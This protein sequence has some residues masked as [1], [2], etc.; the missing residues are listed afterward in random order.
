MAGLYGIENLS[1][2]DNYD[3][4][5]TIGGMSFDAKKDGNKII[6]YSSVPPSYQSGGYYGIKAIL[7]ASLEED[8][9]KEACRKIAESINGTTDAEQYYL[10][11]TNWVSSNY[12]SNFEDTIHTGGEH[13][14]VD[15]RSDANGASYAVAK[16]EQETGRTV[17]SFIL[18]KATTDEGF[19]IPGVKLGGY[20]CEMQIDGETYIVPYKRGQ[21]S[22]IPNE[23]MTS[24]TEGDYTRKSVQ[25]KTKYSAAEQ[26]T[27]ENKVVI[28]NY[29][30]E[31]L[32]EGTKTELVLKENGEYQV[33]INGEVVTSLSKDATI[34][35]AI[36][37]INSTLGSSQ[38]NG[39]SKSNESYRVRQIA[40][41][42]FKVKIDVQEFRQISSAY[43]NAQ[44][45][46][47]HS[48][49]KYQTGMLTGEL[50]AAYNKI[51]DVGNEDPTERIAKTGE[52]IENVTLNIEY[53]L[54]A[55]KNIDH[56]LGIIFNSIVNEI[57]SINSFRNENKESYND[58]SLPY[59]ERKQLLS[60]IIDKYDEELTTLKNDFEKKYGRGEVSFSWDEY[61]KMLPILS[62]AGVFAQVGITGYGQVDATLFKIDS[63]AKIVDFC[64]ENQVVKKLERYLNGAS[65]KSTINTFCQD[66]YSNESLDEKEYRFL[67]NASYMM[68]G[69]IGIWEKAGIY[70]DSYTDYKEYI[71]DAYIKEG[72]LT[73]EKNGQ[74]KL[75]NMS[76]LE[77]SKEVVDDYRTLNNDINTLSNTLYNYRQYEK[78]MP[79]EADMSGRT[80]LDYLVKNYNDYSGKNVDKLKYLNQSELALYFMYKDNSSSKA[81]GYLDAMEDMINQRKGLEMAANR[82]DNYRDG[83]IGFVNAGLDGLGDG[84]SNF[85]D[86]IG[87]IFNPSSTRSAD[88]YMKVYLLSL[89]GSE[90]KYSESLT[91]TQK[92]LIKENYQ[93]M[94]SVGQQAI[95]TIV[96][97]LPG[98]KAIGP[99]LAA[100]SNA[101]NS[102]ESAL[103]NGASTG[104]AYLYGALSGGS[105]LLLNKC[106]SG[107]S[108]LNGKE[109]PQGFNNF[110]AGMEKQAVR[111]F[112][113]TFLDAGIRATILGEPFDINQV[114]S[115][116]FES[117]VQGAFTAA[118]LNGSSK[119]LLKVANGVTV[120]ISQGEY[121]DYNEFRAV[122]E[123]KMWNSSLGQKVYALK[124]AGGEKWESFKDNHPNNIF[125]KLAY[126]LSPDPQNNIDSET[127]K[128][129]GITL[130]DGESLVYDPNS[131]NY[132]RLDAN[133]RSFIIPSSMINYYEGQPNIHNPSY[134]NGTYNNVQD[135]FDAYNTGLI[136]KYVAIDLIKTKLPT[137]DSKDSSSIGHIALSDFSN[138]IKGKDINSNI[139]WS[140]VKLGQLN[141]SPVTITSNSTNNETNAIYNLTDGSDIVDANPKVSVNGTSTVSN[142]TNIIVPGTST[143]TVVGNIGDNQGTKV[144]S[145]SGE[146]TIKVF[147]D[148]APVTSVEV[149]KTL[150]SNDIVY[151]HAT[152]RLPDGK[153]DSTHEGKLE[154]GSIILNGN[155]VSTFK[156]RY[157]VHTATNGVVKGGFMGA[158]E[159]NKD[160]F[161]VIVPDSEIDDSIKLGGFSGDTMFK[162]SVPLGD[163]SIIAVNKNAFTEQEW[164]DFTKEV[165]TKKGNYVAFEGNPEEVIPKILNSNGYAAVKQA[166]LPKEYE[167]LGGDSKAFENAYENFLKTLGSSV[168]TNTAHADTKYSLFENDSNS[169][170]KEAI[171]SDMR[172]TSVDVSKTLS[173]TDTEADTILYGDTEGY[174][175]VTKPELKTPEYMKTRLEG[176]TKQLGKIKDTT[177]VKMYGAKDSTYNGTTVERGQET[178]FGMMN[179]SSLRYNP[180]TKQFESVGIDDYP[181]WL[182]TRTPNST[183]TSGARSVVAKNI[184]SEIK[185]IKGIQDTLDKIENAEDFSSSIDSL[186]ATSRTTVLSILKTRATQEGI[187]NTDKKYYDK[188]IEEIEGVIKT[189]FHEN[190]GDD[191]EIIDIE[192]GVATVKTR[193]GKEFSYKIGALDSQNV[194]EEIRQS[195]IEKENSNFTEYSMNLLKNNEAFNDIAKTWLKGMDSNATKQFAETLAIMPDKTR[196]DTL[197]LLTDKNLLHYYEEAKEDTALTSLKAYR[198][199]GVGHTL[200]V[201]ASTIDSAYTQ[202]KA[203]NRTVDDATIRKL[204][205]TAL[206][207]DTGMDTDMMQLHSVDENGRIVFGAVKTNSEAHTDTG[208]ITR[209]NHAFMSGLDT[210][211]LADTINEYFPELDV[212]ELSLLTFSHSKSNS[213]IRSLSSKA[214]WSQALATL[215]ATIPLWNEAHSD[216]PKI[217]I[218]GEEGKTL[219]QHFQEEGKIGPTVKYDPNGGHYKIDTYEDKADSQ[220]SETVTIEK[221]G[222]IDV[223]DF[224]DG[225]LHE[226]GDNAFSLRDGDANTN[227]DNLSYNQ[228]GKTMYIDPSKVK[229]N[230]VDMSQSEYIKDDFDGTPE[231]NWKK[232]AKAELKGSVF[233]INGEETDYGTQFVLGENNQT[234]GT[235]VYRDANGTAYYDEI[236]TVKD[237]NAIP[238]NTIF[239]GIERKGEIDSGGSNVMR[240]RRL[241]FRL[242][243]DTSAESLAYYEKLWNSTEN[244]K[245][246]TKIIIENTDGVVLFGER[247]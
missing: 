67:D 28:E 62:A 236:I 233:Y 112:A 118:V 190:V 215:D 180:K 74:Y 144:P 240:S 21:A 174:G 51:I 53:S 90:N 40:G 120:S 63:L 30:K 84:I 20:V 100:W 111:G 105:T 228:N 220:A 46:V 27:E 101:G 216:R 11:P 15:A 209:S 182:K 39:F 108:G 155:K 94:S 69:S 214:N 22:V 73:L 76:F 91:E 194:R 169:G 8:E 193:Y 35:D 89:L 192:N 153:I 78:I 199:H 32:P 148:K 107:I 23:V 135:V 171:L 175:Y 196:N 203:E 71:K 234:Y 128:K 42:N 109:I 235:R 1:S 60:D 211:S 110:L 72:L 2:R 151:V 70:R 207:H 184:E 57:F 181:E 170:T 132:I 197:G 161:F 55:Y 49:S 168:I 247:N 38:S 64:E 44:S 166:S 122:V 75:T 18:R 230:P 188:C 243:P 19:T 24:V 140:T 31:M 119:M 7:D 102:V 85:I 133:N 223:Y 88:D 212:P 3:H 114:M 244:G 127:A 218:D 213:G 10:E 99:F 201:L 98:C 9:Y 29:L 59:E 77:T 183:E 41:E 141:D 34:S 80:Y 131:E 154:T 165:A 54:K 43:K 160:K 231:Y 136:D 229:T 164:S 227:N 152:N 208:N 158:S 205:V 92:F 226:L 195:I 245:G 210:L 146:T 61:T 139:D 116:S 96:S 95:P 137:Y 13:S 106:L 113:G 238:I 66:F 82:I 156:Q 83:F 125:V 17:E 87:D 45:Y 176:L 167:G 97:F 52:L 129:M 145:G 200:D 241:V 50:L 4:H 124:T 149:P 5:Y 191:A 222:G 239:M 224:D 6:I 143:A 206:L 56:G 198:S 26:I 79:Y 178:V 221:D 159:W 36:V 12:I 14:Y 225:F 150:T 117:A 48:K 33:I 172:G 121:S 65:F 68:S 37:N 202:A 138:L 204:T 130:K 142:N 173:L 217:L 115:S 81:N 16:I 25:P 163:G 237:G 58:A 177:P 104:Q 147:D 157:T 186:N 47:D 103:Q 189:N 242:P 93:I 187:S 126:N 219:L 162:E 246:G 134:Y 86:G 123:Q 185:S 179:T 232:A